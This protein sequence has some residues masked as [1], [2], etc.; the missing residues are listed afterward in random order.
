MNSL[1]C[2]FH[3]IYEMRLPTTRSQITQLEIGAGRLNRFGF[4]FIYEALCFL[5]LLM[6][7]YYIKNF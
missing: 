7:K 2:L 1:L 4:H 6:P 5:I 3:V